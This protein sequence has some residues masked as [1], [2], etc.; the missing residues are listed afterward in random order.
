MSSTSSHGHRANSAERRFS[1]T[2]RPCGERE[3]PAYRL[4]HGGGRGADLGREPSFLPI[5]ESTA[6]RREGRRPAASPAPCHRMYRKE[7]RNGRASARPP[8]RG[9]AISPSC[10]WDRGTL[11]GMAPDRP[12]VWERFREAP[13]PAS[14]SPRLGAHPLTRQEGAVQTASMTGR[15]V[16]EVAALLGQTPQDVGQLLAGAMDKRGLPKGAERVREACRAEPGPP[17]SRRPDRSPG[18]R[19]TSCR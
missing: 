4:E 1:S 11:N 6:G 18:F 9:P 5:A 13:V 3:T 10:R 7:A 12:K 8:R 17:A 19:T 14:R 15:S 2:V 16:T